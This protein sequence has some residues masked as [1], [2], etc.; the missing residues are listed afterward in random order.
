MRT[1]W[2]WRWDGNYRML[3][4]YDP[5]VF[6]TEAQRSQ[7]QGQLGP[8]NKMLSQKEGQGGGSVVKNIFNTR[9][10]T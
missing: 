9:M 1:E 6:E 2:P 5:N 8:Y 4:T 10:R 3:G 7:V